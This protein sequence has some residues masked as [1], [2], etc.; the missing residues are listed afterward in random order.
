MKPISRRY[1]SS[2]CGE[3]IAVAG[4]A[5]I[6]M[7]AENGLF[8]GNFYRCRSTTSVFAIF[9]IQVIITLE[10][11]IRIAGAIEIRFLRRRIKIAPS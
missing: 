9:F 8:Q 2:A 4:C 10:V 5:R 11:V 1:F 6:L 3:I 7:K